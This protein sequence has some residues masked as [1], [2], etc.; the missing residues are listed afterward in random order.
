MAGAVSSADGV[1]VRYDVHGAG[2]HGRGLPAL[3]LTSPR[4]WA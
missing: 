1:T 2:T 3:V 4:C